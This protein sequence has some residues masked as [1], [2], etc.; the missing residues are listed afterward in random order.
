MP[1]EPVEING[2]SLYVEHENLDEP[3]TPVVMIHGWTADRHR[4]GPVFDHLRRLGLPVVRYDL[5]GHGWSQKG[6]AGSYTL[7]ACV[8]DLQ[9]VIV[10]VV[11][12]VRGAKVA[13]YGH[14]MGGT[15]AFLHA[16]KFPSA[17]E[18]L[19]LVAP[20]L[21]R[22]AGQDVVDGFKALL[23]SYS[24]RFE[25]EFG[26]KKAEQAKLGLEFF[27]HWGDTS[28][29]PEQQATIELGKDML[30][31]DEEVDALATI[32]APT[33]VFIGDADRPDL[34]AAARL[35]HEKVRGSTLDVVAGGHNLAIEAR[36]T[37]PAM[38]GRY[39]GVAGRP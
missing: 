14:S 23:A 20:W 3:G 13:L 32:T 6:L 28:L 8:D 17:V 4:N 16:L 24:R 29:L 25:R 1:A 15:V 31:Y 36:D 27:P 38:V 21:K 12:P 35:I 19:V 10:A 30:E 33:H 9:G 22:T 37:F 34:K 5:R 39:V 18:R 2:V 11:E 26:R 7:A